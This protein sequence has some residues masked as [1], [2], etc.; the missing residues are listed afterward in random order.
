MQNFISGKYD[1]DL[2][3]ETKLTQLINDYK[4]N[5]PHVE[6]ARKLIREG[7]IAE[8][9]TVFYVISSARNGKAIVSEEGTKIDAS[10]RIFFWKQSNCCWNF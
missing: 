7:K 10:G 3:F 2:V 9:S 6:L 8:K 4:S 5:P 1:N